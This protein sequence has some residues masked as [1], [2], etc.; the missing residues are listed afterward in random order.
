M[1]GGRVTRALQHSHAFHMRYYH[2]ALA[3]AHPLE[4]VSLPTPRPPGRGLSTGLPPAPTTR[5]STPTPIT[6]TSRSA[7]S[8]GRT[9]VITRAVDR[10]PGREEVHDP[11]GLELLFDG[12]IRS[13]EI[14][15]EDDQPRPFGGVGLLSNRYAIDR[16]VFEAA[17]GDRN[18]LRIG[19]LVIAPHMRS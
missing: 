10:Q 16:H 2:S 5:W 8:G 6:R 3:G 17:R 15:F 4:R 13:R 11:L 1:G 9:G 19:V 7:P 12:T 14:R 18:T